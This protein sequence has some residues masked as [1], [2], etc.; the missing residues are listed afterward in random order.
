VHVVKNVIF[1][2]GGEE[3]EELVKV[4]NEIWCFMDV[5]EVIV[6]LVLELLR[7]LDTPH[8]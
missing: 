2:S 4:L 3:E 8:R 7:Q 6:Y 1:E 5:L